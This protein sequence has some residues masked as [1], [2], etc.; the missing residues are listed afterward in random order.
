MTVEGTA[1]VIK[2]GEKY[3]IA[4]D[5]DDDLCDL[6]KD[7]FP[8]DELI[9]EP[10]CKLCN[11][12]YKTEYSC[13]GHP[14]ADCYYEVVDDG[15]NVSE[16]LDNTQIAKTCFLETNNLAICKLDVCLSSEAY[17]SFEKNYRFDTLPKGWEYSDKAL[18]NEI[19]FDGKVFD[20][21]REVINAM[22]T[23]SEWIDT[24]PDS[25]YLHE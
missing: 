6:K 16:N 10:V 21:Y 22:E 4:H 17:I 5:L 11:K 15:E 24:L 18:R 23:L 3:Y 20:F 12:G 2:S 13:S 25:S 14:Y 8:V 7:S 9:A 19:S 1:W